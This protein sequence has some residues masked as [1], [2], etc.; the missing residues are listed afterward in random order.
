MDPD[1]YE[2]ISTAFSEQVSAI[3]APERALEW[4]E[5]RP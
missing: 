2:R 3:V 5:L 4:H 1:D